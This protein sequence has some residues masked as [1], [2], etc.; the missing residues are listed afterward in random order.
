MQKVNIPKDFW[1][2]TGFRIILE[3]VYGKKK[4]KKNAIKMK[5]KDNL[6]HKVKFRNCL[7]WSFAIA[8]PIFRAMKPIDF[9]FTTNILTNLLTRIFVSI[10]LFI[11]YAN[12]A[13][14]YV[15][16]I[17]IPVHNIHQY[18][19]YKECILGVSDSECSF[20]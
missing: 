13:T 10:I 18:K 11:L 14:L 7:K 16:C 12:Y 2:K 17:L 3:F 20:T 5:T 15:L 6:K 19:V 8:F 4:K 1:K 9:F